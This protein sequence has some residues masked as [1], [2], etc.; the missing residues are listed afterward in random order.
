MHV[1]V[2]VSCCLKSIGLRESVEHK[3]THMVTFQDNHHTIVL[4]VWCK[5]M[6]CSTNEWHRLA[7]QF[8]WVYKEE[9]IEQVLCD[10]IYS[11]QPENK[12][13]TVLIFWLIGECYVTDGSKFVA[14]FG[15]FGEGGEKV[16]V[17]EISLSVP[18]VF[19]LSLSLLFI[20]GFTSSQSLIIPSHLVSRYLQHFQAC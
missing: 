14:W 7:F 15:E 16:P 18:N 3:H 20:V 4:F 5:L 2:C 19:L 11:W 8:L 6:S 10:E 9:I 12:H 17:L 1:F 13:S